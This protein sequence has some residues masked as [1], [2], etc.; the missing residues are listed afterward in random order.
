MSGMLRLCGIAIA[1]FLIISLEGTNHVSAQDRREAEKPSQPAPTARPG[2]SLG[3]VGAPP[4]LLGPPTAV[5]VRQAPSKKRKR[6]P[7]N[8]KLR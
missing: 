8:H 3:I 7:V 1:L 5:D 4:V 2:S 6:R